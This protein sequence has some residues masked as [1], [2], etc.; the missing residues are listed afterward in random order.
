MTIRQLDP[1]ISDRHIWITQGS[2]KG[3]VMRSLLVALILTLAASSARADALITQVSQF[4]VA[5]TRDRLIAALAVNGIK[6]AARI[7]H[8]ANAKSVGA[9]MPPS[10]LLIFGHPKLGTPLIQA[11]PLIGLDLPMKVLVWQDAGGKVRVSYTPANSRPAMGSRRGTINSKRWKVQCLIWWVKQAAH[12]NPKPATAR[13]FPF[14]PFVAFQP[15]GIPTPGSS[16]HRATQTCIP[17][18]K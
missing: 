18:Q 3:I 4:P 11:N 7:D 2:S 15:R 8:A 16:A 5:E 6:V 1:I 14:W 12:S 10:E 13:V 9:V 17:Y